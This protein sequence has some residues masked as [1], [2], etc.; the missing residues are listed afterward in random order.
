LFTDIVGSTDLK[1]RLG[2][3]PYADLLRR[4]NELFEKI[5]RDERGAVLKHTGDGF[6]AALTTVPHDQEP[7]LGWRPAVGLSIP[8][9]PAGRWKN[10]WARAVRLTG[11]VKLYRG[12]PEIIVDDP[13]QIDVV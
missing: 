3:G 8:Q 2:A 12:S 7:T 5:C 10:G 9:R 13:K 1:G 11:E 4:H 6:F